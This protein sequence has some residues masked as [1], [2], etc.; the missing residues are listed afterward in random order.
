MQ[1]VDLTVGACA[2]QIINFVA[3]DAPGEF[4][5]AYKH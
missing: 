2:V 1:R 5:G 4:C 3:G